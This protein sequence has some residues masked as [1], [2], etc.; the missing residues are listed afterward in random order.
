[1]KKSKCLYENNY[2]KIV[3]EKGGRVKVYSVD[4]NQLLLVTYSTTAAID[5]VFSQCENKHTSLDKLP[6]GSE[7]S[8]PER[9]VCAANKY[10]DIV[11]AGVRHGCD[12][13]YNSLKTTMIYTAIK[14]QVQSC[15]YATNELETIITDSELPEFVR[16]S[17]VQ[18]FLTSKY[19][20]VN[21]HEAWV[22]AISQ[23]QIVR[24]CG[25]DDSKG[26]K[27]YSENL[28]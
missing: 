1:M 17:E 22:I 6:D 5:F 18:G 25:G 13:M 23:N 26:G 20:F 15:S 24:R 4:T 9:I 27:L 21:R 19:R 8:P 14:K 11:I 3:K 7:Y 2:F 28:Y 10:G 12:V 16:N